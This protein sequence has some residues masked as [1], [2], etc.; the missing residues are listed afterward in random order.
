MQR[1]ATL[2]AQGDLPITLTVKPTLEKDAA[3]ATP[4]SP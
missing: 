4:L 1:K 3:C 2:F